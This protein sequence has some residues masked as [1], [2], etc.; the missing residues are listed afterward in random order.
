[1]L[2][3][4]MTEMKHYAR[5]NDLIRKLGGRV[6][7]TYDSSD[8]KLGSDVKEALQIALKGEQDAIHF[9]TELI[10]RLES[11]PESKTISIVKQLAN[12]IMADEYVHVSL[13]NERIAAYEES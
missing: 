1:M 13:L 11:L 3:I 2:G 10:Q 6:G 5:L 7:R 4:A 8:V 12:K 9:Y